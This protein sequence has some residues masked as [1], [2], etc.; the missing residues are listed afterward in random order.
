MSS[1]LIVRTEHAVVVPSVAIQ[2]SQAGNFVFVIKDGAARV[3]PVK[4]LRTSQGLSVV[5]TGLAGG[6]DVVIDGQLLLSDGTRVEIRP[7]RAGA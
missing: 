7:R 2:R 6:E 4:V 3:Q 5:E 1:K